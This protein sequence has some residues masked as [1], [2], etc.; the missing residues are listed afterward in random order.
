MGPVNSRI[1]EASVDAYDLMKALCPTPGTPGVP[2]ARS[3][4]ERQQNYQ[5]TRKNKTKKSGFDT[6]AQRRTEKRSGGKGHGERRTW[7]GEQNSSEALE[8]PRP[9]LCS[10]LCN[11]HNQLKTKPS[12]H[13]NG[14]ATI[15]L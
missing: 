13:S 11:A 4:L 5:T 15:H 12:Q 10:A 7:L 9:V 8:I 14:N 1:T 6:F 3:N 2:L